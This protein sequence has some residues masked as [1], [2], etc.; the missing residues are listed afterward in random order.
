MIEGEDETTEGEKQAQANE[1]I[2]ELVKEITAAARGLTKE[3]IA[4][5]VIEAMRPEHK[6]NQ[7]NEGP[8]VGNRDCFGGC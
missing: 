4:E 2:G 5:M 3:Q 8:D 7:E 1:A 6:N